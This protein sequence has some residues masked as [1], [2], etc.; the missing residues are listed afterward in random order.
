MGNKVRIVWDTAA[1]AKRASS[2]SML[3]TRLVS[4][5][6]K[7]NSINLAEVPTAAYQKAGCTVAEGFMAYGSRIHLE[8]LCKGSGNIWGLVFAM[9]RANSNTVDYKPEYP[10]AT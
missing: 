10:E 4:N 9:F 1:Y 5:T 8:S 3:L 7:V 6:L 2:D